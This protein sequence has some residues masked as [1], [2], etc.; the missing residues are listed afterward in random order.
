LVA[1]FTRHSEFGWACRMTPNARGPTNH[2]LCSLLSKV[3]QAM[4]NFLSV[5]IPTAP[6]SQAL[7][8]FNPFI[9]FFRLYFAIPLVIFLL[10][11][12]LPSTKRTCFFYLPLRCLPYP[13]ITYHFVFVDCLLYLSTPFAFSDLHKSPFPAP[14]VFRYSLPHS[15]F[16]YL[17]VVITPTAVCYDYY[18]PK[19]LLLLFNSF[20][21]LFRILLLVLSSLFVI[22][23]NPSRRSPSLCLHTLPIFALLPSKIQPSSSVQ[24]LI[25]V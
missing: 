9:F 15:P 13:R 24:C 2:M 14:M 10:Q 23:F 8:L 4:S 1:T 12:F 16:A 25:S 3:C 17:Y 5:S 18:L 6:K 19:I 22:F 7:C 11:P 20:A 21:F